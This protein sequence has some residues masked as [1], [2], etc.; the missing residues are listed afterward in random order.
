MH[1]ADECILVS[2]DIHRS[3]RDARVAIQVRAVRVVGIISGIDARRTDLQTKISIRQIHKTG[4][5]REIIRADRQR[6][7]AA[8]G[9]V[10]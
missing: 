10:V 5:V 1:R 8:I 3:T 9:D 6:S 4:R 7:Y 2:A